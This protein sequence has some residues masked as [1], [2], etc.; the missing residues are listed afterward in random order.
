M[1]IQVSTKTKNKASL[2]LY[3]QIISYL[4]EQELGELKG[5]SKAKIALVEAKNALR[6]LIK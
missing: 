3:N 4:F 6:E 5:S 2:K 1:G